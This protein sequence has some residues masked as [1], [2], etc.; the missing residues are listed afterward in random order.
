ME[1]S[2]QV[3][4]NLAQRRQ[5]G[6]RM[7]R[8]DQARR[9]FDSGARGGVPGRNLLTVRSSL[10]VSP[11]GS[12]PLPQLPFCV[13]DRQLRRQQNGLNHAFRISLVLASDVERRAVIDRRADDREA[14][15][16]VYRFAER[17]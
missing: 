8:D 5:P 12:E 9:G 13:A 14:N 2:L 11:E 10:M 4:C 7:G 3:T 15:R 6:N 17:E 16:H 1:N